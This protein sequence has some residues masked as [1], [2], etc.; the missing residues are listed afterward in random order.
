MWII[1]VMIMYGFFGA[2]EMPGIS[3]YLPP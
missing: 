2:T 1:F 3:S